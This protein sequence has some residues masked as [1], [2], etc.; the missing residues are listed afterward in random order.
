MINFK[1]LISVTLVLFSVIDIV[2]SIPILIGLQKKGIKIEAAKASAISLLI[3]T[4][5]LYGGEALLHLFGIDVE[6]FAVAGA[7]I[8]F[9]MGMEM[10]LGVHIFHDQPDA[11]SGTIVPVAFPLIAGAGTMTTIIAL[12]ADFQS[13]NIQ[14]GIVLNIIFVFLVL[15]SSNWISDKLGEGGANVLRKVFGIILLAIAIKL[16]RDNFH[17][18]ITP[19]QS[20]PVHH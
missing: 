5:F 13:I 10:V 2:G 6:S 20:A 9:L 11:K 15:R 18:I 16:F 19:T 17:L 1:E 8:L 7:I 3:M 14:L 4:I 12:K